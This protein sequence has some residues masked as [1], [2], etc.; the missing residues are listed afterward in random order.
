MKAKSESTAKRSRKVSVESK[1]TTEKKAVNK[2][3]KK[4]SGPTEAEIR[5]KAEQ[6]YK[7]RIAKN[8]HGTQESDW[9]KAE[10]IL[11]GLK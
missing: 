1:A 10:K 5:A 7:E 3:L 8:I 4:E 11:R 9:L 6:L 2:V